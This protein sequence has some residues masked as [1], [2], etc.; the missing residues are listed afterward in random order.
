[1][2]AKYDCDQTVDLDRPS[3]TRVNF[4]VLNRTIG[5]V[6][7]STGDG[8]I[9]TWEGPRSDKRRHPEGCTRRAQDASARRAQR[10]TAN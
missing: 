10:V 1:M 4:K 8:E 6:D 7:T 3:P 9:L 2:C 5:V